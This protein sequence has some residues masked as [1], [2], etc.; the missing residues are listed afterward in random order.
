MTGWTVALHVLGCEVLRLDL[1]TPPADG[2]HHELTAVNRHSGD[3]GFAATPVRPYW[4]HDPDEA[5]AVARAPRSS[6]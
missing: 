6:T 2:G 5:P 1:G 4:N 3:F